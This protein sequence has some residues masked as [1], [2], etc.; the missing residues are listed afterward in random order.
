MPAPI[1][2]TKLSAFPGG[3]AAQLY[4]CLHR[5]LALPPGTR[6]FVCHDDPDGREARW[7]TTVAEQRAANIHVHVHVHDG[8]GEVEF[9]A[10][11]RACNATLAVPALMLT[12]LQVNIRAGQLPPAEG[13]FVA[14]LRIPINAL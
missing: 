10:M 12:S 14:H 2:S 9:V 8:V 6:L 13:N 4:H 11:R 3:D 7:Q 5:V 1:A